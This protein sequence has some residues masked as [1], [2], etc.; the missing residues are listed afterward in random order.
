MYS[1][2]YVADHATHFYLLG[3]PDFVVG[4][5][6]KPAERNI[7]GVIAKVG[8]EIGGRVIQA[9]Q[10][11][12]EAV[13]ILGGRYINPVGALPG[14]VSKPIS[15]EERARLEQIARDSVDFGELSLK[16]FEDIVLKNKQYVDMIISDTFTHR[17]YY[18]GLVDENNCTNF[19]DGKV[20]VVDP[21]G[22]EFVKYAPAEYLQHIAERVEPWTYLKFPY[23]KNVGW[24]GFVDGKD[25]GVYRATPL[26]R[27]NAADGM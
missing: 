22:K 4:P 26:S 21:N 13:G 6:A 24:K 8:L 2:F 3:G 18:M 14:G 19:Y 17:T 20:R 15:E 5:E 11:T 9:L 25:S 16:L 12:H 7:F 23:L 1:F 27:C 10:D